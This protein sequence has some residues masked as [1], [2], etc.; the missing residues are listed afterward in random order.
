MP[1]LVAIEAQL[2]MFKLT[3]ECFGRIMLKHV[4]I[5]LRPQNVIH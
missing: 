4:D 2:E 3:G 5:S 1:P